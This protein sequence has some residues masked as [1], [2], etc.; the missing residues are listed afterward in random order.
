MEIKVTHTR[1]GKY[2]DGV[3]SEHSIGK[4]KHDVIFWKHIQNKINFD[5]DRTLFADDNEHVIK[6]AKSF[7]IKHLALKSKYDSTKPAKKPEDLFYVHHF[8]DIL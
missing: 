3:F 6:V 1:I 5:K 7:G 8:D 2:F 4:S